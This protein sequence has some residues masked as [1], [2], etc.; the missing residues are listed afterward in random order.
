MPPS[1]Q[2]RSASGFSL[3]E[4]LIVIAVIAVL[5][6][7]SAQFFAST[8]AGVNLTQGG[9]QI[10]YALG[11]ARQIADNEG[12]TASVVFVR[13]G[14][15]PED[16]NPKFRSIE[17]WRWLPSG[18]AEAVEVQRLPEGV[19][20]SEKAAYSPLLTTVRPP[21]DPLSKEPVSVQIDFH[22]D[23][24]TS[25]KYHPSG[26]SPE[27]W[28]VTV[29]AET[30]DPAVTGQLPR[31]FVTIQIDPSTGRLMRYQP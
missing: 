1:G 24:G 30:Q 2:P 3:V 25:L 6:T 26:N 10:L 12:T 21:R 11:E 29:V 17:I 9:E 23:G 8:V 14:L 27:S 18:D 15:F 13:E 7:M 19:V 4:L 16:S 20:L 5:Y 31:N 28:F 22:A